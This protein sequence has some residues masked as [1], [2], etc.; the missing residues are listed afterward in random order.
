MDSSGLRG[1]GRLKLQNVYF[2][3]FQT[4]MRNPSVKMMEGVDMYNPFFNDYFLAKPAEWM[5][6]K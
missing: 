2:S 4:V 6:K 1:E 5:L 3:N